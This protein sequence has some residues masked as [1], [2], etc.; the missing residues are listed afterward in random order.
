MPLVYHPR[1][2]GDPSV[3]IADPSAARI[4]LGFNPTH[5]DLGTIIRTAWNWHAKGCAF[6][7]LDGGQQG[8]FSG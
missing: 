7:R 4:A 2:E 6:E 8:A 5:S 3:L 1:R